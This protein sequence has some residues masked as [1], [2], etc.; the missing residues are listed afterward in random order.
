M[1]D[2]PALQKALVAHPV[3]LPPLG[4]GQRT[5]NHPDRACWPGAEEGHFPVL[6]AL[7]VGAW[8]A[9][10]SQAWAASLVHHPAQGNP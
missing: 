3:R 10:L 5:P 7:M 4:E 1:N 9:A 6:T 2:C 8:S